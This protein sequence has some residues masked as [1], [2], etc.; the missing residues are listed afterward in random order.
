MALSEK[1]EGAVSA[2]KLPIPGNDTL[3]CTSIS[4][5]MIPE[6]KSKSMIN[7]LSHKVKKNEVI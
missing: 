7:M 1:T 6:N 2:M 3:S 4:F 5:L